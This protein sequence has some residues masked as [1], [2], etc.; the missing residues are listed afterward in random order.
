MVADAPRTEAYRAAIHAHRRSFKGATVLDVGCGSG[1]LSVFAAKAGAKRV[2]CVEYTEMASV[3]EM[4]AESNGAVCPFNESV[5]TCTCARHASCSSH[6]HQTHRC[7]VEATC[8]HVHLTLL[9][10]T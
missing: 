8:T 7:H 6:D 2:F 10:N 4:V 1:V 5:F 3:A 9:C